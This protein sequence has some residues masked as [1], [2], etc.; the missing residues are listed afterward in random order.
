M[1]H[2]IF[3]DTRKV[4]VGESRWHDEQEVVNTMRS[5]YQ[6][7]FVTRTMGHFAWPQ[8]AYPQMKL[9]YSPSPKYALLDLG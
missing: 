9:K 5:R 3:R 7:N 4:V 6:V 1:R 8:W 2:Q